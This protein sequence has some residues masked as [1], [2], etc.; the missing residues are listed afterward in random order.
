LACQLQANAPTRAN[1]HYCGHDAVS[2]C[3]LLL[4]PHNVPQAFRFPRSLQ[5]IVLAQSG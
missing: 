4:D 2:S 3:L 1:N 5:R